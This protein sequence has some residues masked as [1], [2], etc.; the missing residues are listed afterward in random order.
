MQLALDTHTWERVP[1]AGKTVHVRCCTLSVVWFVEPSTQSS[2]CACTH[3][4]SHAWALVKTKPAI[5]CRTTTRCATTRR[6]VAHS[7]ASHTLGTL[8][9]QPSDVCRPHPTTKADVVTTRKKRNVVSKGFL[10]I[11]SDFVKM[12]V[13]AHCMHA[14]TA[15]AIMLRLFSAATVCGVVVGAAARDAPAT[16]KVWHLTDVHVDP[17]Y[18]VRTQPVHHALHRL[19]A[20]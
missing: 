14:L 9:Q 4:G 6:T 17:Y 20:F 3:L 18:V 19:A 7:H 11:L 5:V 12:K 13:D 2:R 15:C 8:P 16:V 10:S 1:T